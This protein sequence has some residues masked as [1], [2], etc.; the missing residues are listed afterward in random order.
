MERL[1]AIGTVIGLFDHLPCAVMEDRLDPG[2]ILTLYTDGVTE[3]FNDREEEFGDARLIEALFRHRS[4]PA[5]ELAASIVDDVTRF[6]T[7][8]QFDDI[9]LIIAKRC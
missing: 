1:D 8:D 4:S 7:G 9:M 6:S 2:D 5:R 3:A